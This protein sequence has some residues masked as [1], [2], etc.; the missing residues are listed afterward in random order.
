MFSC[1]NDIPIN[2]EKKIINGPGS[3]YK[4]KTAMTAS[5]MMVSSETTNAL[6]KC[7]L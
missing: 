5:H 7:T 2:P 4:N 3:L 6:Y 1:Q